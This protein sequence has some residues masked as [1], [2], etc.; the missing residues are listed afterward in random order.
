MHKFKNLLVYILLTC[1][2]MFASS[3]EKVERDVIPVN[4]ELINEINTSSQSVIR[5][6][7]EE[8]SPE[9][10]LYLWQ[11]HLNQQLADP[12]LS[13][14]LK[15]HLR[16]L[17]PLLTVEFFKGFGTEESKAFMDKFT[18][19][20]MTVPISTGQFTKHELLVAATVT[21]L[22][23]AA[24]NTSFNIKS[25]SGKNTDPT[26]NSV[27][28]IG[29]ECYY[30]ASCDGVYTCNDGGCTRGGSCGIFGSSNCS[31]RCG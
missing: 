1:V 3:C 28:S 18:F 14:A 10:K 30:S 21:G 16:K 26:V 22:G 8:L 24:K 15:L 31:G 29:C 9:E 25:N 19:E 23:K 5:L 11:Q 7:M 6:A 2:S 4:V 27:P 12:K 20:W 13:P 17:Q